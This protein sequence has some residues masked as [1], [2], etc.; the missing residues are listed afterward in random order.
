MIWQVVVGG[1]TWVDPDRDIPSAQVS[2][3]SA[4]FM[5]FLMV[6]SVRVHPHSLV[7]RVDLSFVIIVSPFF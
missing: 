4:S 3:L 5:N 6:I 1:T 2:M 7:G